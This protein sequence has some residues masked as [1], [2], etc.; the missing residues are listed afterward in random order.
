MSNTHNHDAS[1]CHA[2]CCQS[3]ASSLTRRDFLTGTGIAISALAMS[4]LVYN[5]AFAA[6][7]AL[8]PAPNRKPLIVKP[9]LAYETPTRQPQTSWR[10]WGGIETDAQANE[11]VAR[12]NAEL[13]ALKQ[14]ADFPVTFLPVTLAKSPDQMTKAPDYASAD[15]ILLYAAG[16]P[17]AT[18]ETAEKSG[19]N[20]IFFLRHRSGP[21]YLWYEII[22]PRY[23]HQHTDILSTKKAD[24]N[25]VVVDSQPEILWRLRSLGGLKNALGTKM[26]AI[27]GPGG[28]ATPNAPELA[29]AKWKLDIETVSYRQLTPILAAALADNAAIALA[30]DRA[31]KYLADPSV[32]LETDKQFVVNAFLLE[33][34][35]R[36]LMQKA[37][38]SAMTI[39]DCMG[40]IMPI[41]K[42]TA[43][44]TLSLLNDAGFL[45]FCESDFVVIPSGLLLCGI[46][47]KP[48][49]LNDPT[50]P[51]DGVIT[52]AHCTGPR[53]MDGKNLEPARI[54]THFESDYGASPKVEMKKGT[55]VT[56]IIPDFA[57][58]RYV[59]FLGEIVE[60][61]F[62]PI[63]RCQIEVA[64]KIPDQ[65]I[66]QNMPGFHWEMV[67]GDYMKETGY[68]LKK[69]PIAWQAL[70]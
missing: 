52:L 66:A 17:Q 61:P 5:S 60:A 42:T 70:A 7:A 20:V 15:T 18:L 25:D 31:N 48:H 59:G 4:N 14:Q 46:S 63:C 8:Q 24:N 57:A 49:F 54:V 32:K 36:S 23:L 45:A 16:G 29:K 64:Y 65:L 2:H 11:E 22:S 26:V 68:A 43:C 10:S 12:I 1:Q 50:Y 27:G 39:N 33:Q 56:N 69:I 62:L 3:A 34:V 9:V 28:W 41:S 21:V 19:K 13:A 37:N 30:T 55:K 67:Y 38:C 47:G 51:H 6:E 40:A 35:F 58:N 53:K 44:L